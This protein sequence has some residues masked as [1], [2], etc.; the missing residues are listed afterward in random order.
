MNA[1]MSLIK[2]EF[3]L[4]TRNKYALGSILLYVATTVFV[5]YQSFQE[6]TFLPVWNSLFWIIL[7]FTSLNA[8]AKSFSLDSGGLQLYL[9]TLASP[10]SVIIS[11]IIYNTLLVT[12]VAFLTL[13]CY[14]LFLGSSVIGEANLPMY[15]VGLVLGAMGFSSILTMIAGIASRTQNN[16]GL[17]AV[18]GF[19]LLLPMILV[20]IE[21]TQYA[22]LDKEWSDAIRPVV[23]LLSLDVLSAALG[24]L[25]FPYLWRE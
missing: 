12:V 14:V 15:L 18:L 16:I 7:I 4:E 9:Y 3:L 23:L 19:P 8:I 17:M 21:I 1:T 5:V 25:L 6:V 2:K 20:L 22:L 24:F 13:A 10:Q 11:K